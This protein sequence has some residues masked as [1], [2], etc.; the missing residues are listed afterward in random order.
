MRP[1]FPQ[2]ASLPSSDADVP[3]CSVSTSTTILTSTALNSPPTSISQIGDVL[4]DAS[5][6][7]L[8]QANRCFLFQGNVRKI[9]YITL[10]QYCS[11]CGRDFDAGMQKCSSA[12]CA[13]T[14]S[15]GVRAFAKFMFSDRSGTAEIT[16]N[17]GTCVEFLSP[18]FLSGVLRRMEAEKVS[19][20]FLSAELDEARALEANADGWGAERQR[21]MEQACLRSQE[22]VI[23]LVRIRKDVIAKDGKL[24]CSVQEVKSRF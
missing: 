5:S 16:G 18:K 23:I 24:K 1:L 14:E 12:P 19:G 6:D 21:V 3:G 9:R 11:L 20:V 15:G 13:N 8:L 4:G 17:T 7:P 22:E 10:A 2:S